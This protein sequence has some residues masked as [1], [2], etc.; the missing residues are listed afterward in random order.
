MFGET[1]VARTLSSLCVLLS[2]CALWPPP[3]PVFLG[4]RPDPIVSPMRLFMIVFYVA[5]EEGRPD[6]FAFDGCPV[7]LSLFEDS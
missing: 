2:K 5:L 6:A 4:L 1:V 7:L 3:L